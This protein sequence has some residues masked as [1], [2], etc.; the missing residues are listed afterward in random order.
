MV[1][2]RP[3][4]RDN[5][6]QILNV[7]GPWCRGFLD[8][9][10]VMLASASGNEIREKRTAAV[11]PKEVRRREHRTGIHDLL[12]LLVVVLVAGFAMDDYR[13]DCGIAVVNERTASA[14]VDNTIRPAQ[15]TGIS[16]YAFEIKWARSI[17][18]KFVACAEIALVF[19]LI[20]GFTESGLI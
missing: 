4:Q 15:Y 17:P 8:E 19:L 11:H 1:A 7:A 2:K 16:M 14:R 18:V 12:V 20:H 10:R 5:K 6:F 3:A 13:R 9:H